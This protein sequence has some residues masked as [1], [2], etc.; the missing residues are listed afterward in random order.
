MRK[1]FELVQHSKIR[2]KN[3]VFS[4]GSGKYLRAEL[5]S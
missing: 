1:E 5:S 4:A 2:I 3:D